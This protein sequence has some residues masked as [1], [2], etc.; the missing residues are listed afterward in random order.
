MEQLL[1]KNENICWVRKAHDWKRLDEYTFKC[2]DCL[3]VC[4]NE[5]YAKDQANKPRKFFR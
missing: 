4:D 5:R 2:T 1:S 3:E